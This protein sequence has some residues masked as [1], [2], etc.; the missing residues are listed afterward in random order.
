MQ[1]QQGHQ[2]VYNK[3]TLINL[4]IIKLMEV[5]NVVTGLGEVCS[6]DADCLVLG[7]GDSECVR[8]YGSCEPTCQCDA[9]SYES[10]EL[11]T[12]QLGQ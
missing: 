2:C 3:D 5:L 1:V 12:C 6:D 10:T 4:N 8:V 7:L 11:N 9:N